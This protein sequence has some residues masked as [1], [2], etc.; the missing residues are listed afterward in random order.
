[1][2]NG[3]VDKRNILTT[4]SSAT[5]ISIELGC[6]AAKRHADS[7]GIDMADAPGVDIVGPAE[8]VLSELPEESVSSAYSYH[9]LEHLSDVPRLVD[10]LGRVM[11][12]NGRVVSVVPH[13]ADPFYYSDPT[14]RTP[15]GLYSFSYFC[16]DTPFRRNVPQYFGDPL[17]DLTS[18]SLTFGAD[19]PAYIRYA[20]AKA[21]GAL[22][23]RT[24][25]T[26]EFFERNLTRTFPPLEIRFE[27]V[28]RPRNCLAAY[29]SG[30][31]VG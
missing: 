5:P 19:R 14:H 13:H 24:P 18:V 22:A 31:R 9:F 29:R 28:R 7:I 15:F 20:L 23:N 2:T 26:L 17:F 30:S 25:R 12:D 10:L 27:M 4:T 3:I 8:L 6:G 16:E 21:V 11:K 1:M